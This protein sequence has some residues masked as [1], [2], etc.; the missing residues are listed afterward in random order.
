MNNQNICKKKANNV[1]DNF[2]KII[3]R[4]QQKKQESLAFVHS[5]YCFSKKSFFY[6]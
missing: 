4:S 2:K 3:I 6:R 5:L 1:Q